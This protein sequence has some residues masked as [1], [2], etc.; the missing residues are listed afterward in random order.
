MRVRGARSCGTIVNRWSIWSTVQHSPGIEALLAIK[1]L[2]L[3]Q[4]FVLGD[5]HVKAG[6]PLAIPIVDHFADDF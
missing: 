2:Y 4:P 5:V 1:R 3:L 6:I